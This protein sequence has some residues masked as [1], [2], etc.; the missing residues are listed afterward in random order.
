MKIAVIGANGKAGQLIVKEAV[1][2]G[3]DVTAIVRGENKSVAEKVITKDVFTLTKEDLEGFDVVVDAFGA[4]VPETILQIGEAVKY[5]GNLLTGTNTRL[6]VVG[7]AGSLFVDSEHTMTVDQGPDFPE[8]WKPLSASHGVGLLYLRDS[9]DLNWTYVSPAADFQAEG[10]RTGEYTLAGE[11]LTLNSKGESTL[12]YADYALA[13]VDVI[14][15]GEHNK[16][17]ISVVSK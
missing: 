7:G 3:L 10:E 2:K 12:S 13:M 16:E 17:R 6:L 15:S 8:A 9:K 5:L 4:W 11:E 14:A 1:E